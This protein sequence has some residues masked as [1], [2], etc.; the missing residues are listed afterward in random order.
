MT[1]VTS[2]SNRLV[3]PYI[4]DTTQLIQD[5]YIFTRVLLFHCNFLTRDVLEKRAEDHRGFWGQGG[6]GPQGV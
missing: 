6:D 5:P 1:K 3:K 4:T 2:E